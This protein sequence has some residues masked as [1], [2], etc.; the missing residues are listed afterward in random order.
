VSEKLSGSLKLE[1]IERAEVSVFKLVQKDSF[2][3]LKDAKLATLCPFEDQ[4]GLIRVKSKLTDR[5]DHE[6]FRTPIV[7]PSK[8]PVVRMLIHFKHVKACHAGVQYMISILREDFWILNARKTVKSVISSCVKCQRY[9][10][11]NLQTGPIGLPEDRVKDAAV[12]QISG[13]DFAGPV[14]LRDGQKAWICLFTCAV[15]RAVHIELVSSLST[16]EFL[17]ALRRFIARRGRPSVMYSDNATN[18]VGANNAFSKL[19]W[20]EIQEY[21]SVQRMKWKFN[22]PSSPW[23]GGWWERLIGMMKQLLR[24]CLGNSSLTYEEFQTV[25][26]DCESVVNSRPLTYIS[27]DVNDLIPLTPAMF[28]ADIKQTGTPDVDKIDHRELNRRVRYC[29]KLKEDLR[30]RFRSEYL[31]VLMMKSK[32]ST[33]NLKVGEVVIVETDDKRR[34]NWPLA[35]VEEL[36]PGRDGQVRLAKLKTNSGIILRPVQK[37]Y[38]LEVQNCDDEEFLKHKTKDVKE[39]KNENKELKEKIVTR[40]GRTIKRPNRFV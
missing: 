2:C 13:V 21:S 25:L 19:D 7:L 6:N 24:K 27:N 23:W 36:V 14:Y 10:G 8:H 32:R 16:N 4:N 30:K 5:K 37:I 15:Y 33:R 28:L 12:F 3:G 11:K 1:E 35:V 34:L 40:S 20:D 18:F 31:G 26:C 22:P 9:K 38:P 17:Q 29:Q 39:T